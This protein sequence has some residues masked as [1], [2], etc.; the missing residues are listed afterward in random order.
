MATA[1]LTATAA[2]VLTGKPLDGFGRFLTGNEQLEKSRKGDEPPREHDASEK[3][4]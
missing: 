3:E 1:A 2:L 4:F